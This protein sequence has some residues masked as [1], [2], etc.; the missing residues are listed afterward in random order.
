MIVIVVGIIMVNGFKVSDRQGNRKFVQAFSTTTFQI[1]EAELNIWGEYIPKYMQKVEMAAVVHAMALKLGIL[2]YTATMEETNE[3]RT[4]TATKIGADADTRIQ[5][6]ETIKSLENDTFSAKN[7]LIVNIALKNKCESVTYFEESLYHY[8]K[9][10]EIMPTTGLTITASKQ[11][12][13]SDIVAQD[14]MTD[15]IQALSGEVKS[16]YLEDELKTAYGYTNI[17]EDYITSGG[18]KINMDLAVTYN[19]IEDKT[20]LYGAIPVITFEY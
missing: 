3:K 18:E 17:L 20:Y 8:F 9:E 2:D 15:L 10:L 19:E 11:G 13:I 1:E 7:Y 12:Q 6:V 5:L 4:Y 14:V 16:I